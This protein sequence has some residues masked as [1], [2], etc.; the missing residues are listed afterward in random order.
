MTR[1]LIVR[2]TPIIYL[3][4]VKNILL[5]IQPALSSN[6]NTV[7]LQAKNLLFIACSL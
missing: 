1:S 5:I 4:H 7:F 6:L 2:Q 3:T